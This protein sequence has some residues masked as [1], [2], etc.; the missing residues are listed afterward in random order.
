MVNNNRKLYNFILFAFCCCLLF[1]GLFSCSDDANNIVSSTTHN[2][3][4]EQTYIP[5]ILADGVSTLD[6]WASVVDKEGKPARGMK[7]IFESSFGNIGETVFTDDYGG[8]KTVLTS[9]ASETDI[10]V[11]ITAIVVDTSFNSLGKK[12]ANE[13]KLNLL[14]NKNSPQVTK[15]SKSS[16]ISEN[17]AKL[18]VRLVGVTITATT[19]DNILPADGLSQTNFSINLFETTSRKPVKSAELFISAS[20]RNMTTSAVTNQD[21]LANIDIISGETAGIDTLQI[22]FGNVLTTSLTLQ[23]VLPRLFIESTLAEIIADGESQTQIIATLLSQKNTPIA[24]A[25]IGFSATDGIVQP[26]AQTDNFGKA[27]VTLVSGKSE[28]Q[29]VAIFAEFLALKDTITVSFV[30]SAAQNLEFITTEN[31][32]LLRDGKSERT[33]SLK[34][35]DAA[36]S[37][38]SNTIINLST[39]YG[40]VPDS[41]ITDNAGLAEFSYLSDAGRTNVSDQIHATVGGKTWI[42]QLDLHG[43]IIL[44]TVLPDSIP[45]DGTSESAV[46]VELKRAGSN[47]PVAGYLLE[48]G[49]NI[50]NVPKSLT[51][52]DRGKVSFKYIAGQASGTAE[53]TTF[54]G[55][56][57]E[58]VNVYLYKN[59]STNLTLQSSNSFIWVKESGQIEQTDIIA[60]VLGINGQPT[61][62]QYAVEFSF[63]SKPGGGEFLETTSGATGNSVVVNTINGVAKAYLR[64]GT[65]SGHVQ[66][67]AHIVDQPD[68]A[69]QSTKLII[70]SGPPYMWINPSNPN[71]VVHHSNVL[72]EPGQHN[73]SFVNPLR[74]I[75]VSALFADKYNNPVEQNTA[76]YFTTSGGSI[77]SD[78]LTNELG[79]TSV[80]LQ[81]SNPF[82][83]VLSPDA[84][85]LTGLH[86]PNPN[87]E[88][89][90]LNLALPDY[91]GSEISNTA[92]FYGPNDGIATIM[93]VTSGLDQ[94]G[95]TIDVWA[96]SKVIFSQALYRFTAT[97]DRD[98]I[99]VGE[100]ANINIRCYDVNGNPVATGSE[101][102][103]ETNAGKVTA[104]DLMPPEERYGYG[105]T[106]FSTQIVNTLN[107]D[108]DKTKPAS[109]EIK[110][111]SPNGDAAIGLGVIL[112]VE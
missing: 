80:I 70:R 99:R 38:Q 93:A 78:A 41:V 5:Y 55:Q 36:G 26:T 17:E 98:S 13:F 9:I 4:L 53:I 33:L 87:N 49:T 95:N 50:G 30:K 44:A 18:E 37:P 47:I 6:I 84:Q 75:K 83:V 40:I 8:A 52:D 48:F 25:N 24:R 96:T 94:F 51:T 62:A 109:I 42:K 19:K 82:P 64:S 104:T 102:T 105:T 32:L 16:L 59:F 2:I 69:A 1:I 79:K 74:E 31:G 3:E 34:A 90:M 76:V 43:L 65:K 81:N 108:E 71:D 60:T 12:M 112:V 86:F 100:K 101:L 61:T 35:T 88:N 68:V 85:Q 29:N 106:F 22:S 89:V 14:T 21:G 97:I 73:T 10:L 15:L 46:T 107:P 56:L 111:K 110:L 27:T 23:Y 77:T 20:I 92:G 54:C 45:A 57:L 11:E 103:A 39:D 58:K 66:V 91:E 67:R 7:V 72:V 63:T 28:N